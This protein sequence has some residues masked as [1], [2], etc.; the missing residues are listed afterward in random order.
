M[1]RPITI[2]GVAF[3]SR[4]VAITSPGNL[5]SI[6]VLE[7]IGLKF[8]RTIRLAAQSPELKLFEAG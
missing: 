4:I 7:K 8:E 5:A 2:G 1:S 3:A 6:A